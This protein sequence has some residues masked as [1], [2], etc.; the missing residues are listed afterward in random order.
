MRWVGI[1][2]LSLCLHIS[3]AHRGDYLAITD[4]QLSE[5]E[6][7]FIY[8]FLIE[9]IKEMSY[10]DVRIDFWINMKSV[11][12]KRYELIDGSQKFIPERFIIPKKMLDIDNDLVNI[13]IT[14]IFG[15][16]KDWGGWDS[17][18]SHGRQVNTLYSEFYVDA[19]WRMKK[20]DDQGNINPVPIHFYLHD[21]DLVVGTTV[22]IDMVDIKVKNA[23]ASSF[24]SPLTFN[25]IPESDFK[26]YFSCASQNDN[27]FSVQAF[28]MASFKASGSTTMDFDQHSDFWND[29]EE[30]DAT[31]WFFTFNIPPDR[32]VGFEDVIDVQVTIHY[33]NLTFSDDVMGVRI[34]R[35]NE[36]VPV[37]PG[38]YRGD[39]HL[40]SMFTQNDAETGLPMC[41]TKEAGKLIGLDWITTTDHTSD[42]DNYGTTV[43]ANWNRIQADVQQFNQEDPSLI[44]IAGQEVALNNHEDKLVHM[45]AYPSY[46]T[47]Y[48]FPFIGD[49]DGDLVSTSVSINSALNN[50]SNANGFAYA[51]HPFATEDALPTIPV[52]GGI[53][54]L[55]SSGFPGNGN[56][57]PQTGGNIISNDPSAPSDILSSEEM[58]LI[59]EGLVGAQIWNVRNTLE[60][61]GDELDPWD[62]DNG[63]DGFTVVDTNSYGHHVKRFRQGQEIVNYINQLGLKMKNESDGYQNWKLFY[64]AG[65]DAHG[66]FNFSNTDDF[67]GFGKIN[68][69]AVGKVNTLVFCPDGMKND[70]S[71]VLEALK[72]GRNTL[73]D[74]PILAIGISE[75]GAD[76]INEIFMGDDAI[77]NLKNTDT[78]FLNFNY[79]TTAEFGDV[80]W[81]KFYVGTESGEQQIELGDTWGHQGNNHEFI[82]LDDVLEKIWGAGAIPQKEYFYIRAEMQTLVDLTSNA[83]VYRTNYNIHH[84]FTN[85]IWIKY[86]EVLPEVNE[87]TLVTRPNP[88]F[89]DFYLD[90]KTTEET[91][92]KLGIYD[93]T[94]KL[95]L[96]NE[97][98][99]N[100][101]KTIHI[102]ENDLLLAQGTYIIRAITA[103]EQAE[104]KVV[105]IK[106]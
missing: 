68:D 98:H 19:P 55:G 72:N 43:A 92:V 5:T 102:T 46:E 41:A 44:Y 6:D 35:S 52:D 7:A 23:S 60:T 85:P 106:E 83:N 59:K 89:Q 100:L 104:I 103:N 22:Q 9:N 51:A 96:M 78:Y 33:G 73:S 79:A 87:L 81:F 69:N 25:N 99:V 45:L 101:S 64:S 70:G 94:G 66:S 86:D 84:S 95:I 67:A 90:I 53:W 42:F 65:A 18:R 32:L 62:V 3:Y 38:F 91:D 26:S 21:A 4:V 80:Q 93:P 15:K 28:D 14:Q 54:N 39:T 61:T 17:E 12:F 74:G 75:N 57:Y 49:G 2:I 8:S 82:A 27:A 40:H 1:L 58:V 30:V 47:P 34:F 11:F 48:S 50:I 13:E 37:L 24:G 31:Y 16:K 105:K 20:L 63:G 88:F 97:Y 29:Y 10:T 56:N 71:G 36:D 77:I 76:N